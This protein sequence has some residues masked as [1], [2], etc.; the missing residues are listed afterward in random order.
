MQ[1]NAE[2]N[3]VSRIRE[4]DAEKMAATA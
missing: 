1:N 2:H 3:Q 4:A